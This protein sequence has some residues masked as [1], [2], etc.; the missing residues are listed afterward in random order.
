MLN[1]LSRTKDAVLYFVATVRGADLMNSIGEAGRTAALRHHHL[2]MHAASQQPGREENLTGNLWSPHSLRNKQSR[3]QVVELHGSLLKHLHATASCPDLGTERPSVSHDQST[4]PQPR[5]CHHKWH[6]QKAAT[7]SQR[8]HS[9]SPDCRR[10]R[11]HR[12]RPAGE[13]RHESATS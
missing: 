1:S 2:D 3:Q 10:L 12:R 7:W 4:T 5:T 13:G 11:Q 9:T 6:Q 8:P